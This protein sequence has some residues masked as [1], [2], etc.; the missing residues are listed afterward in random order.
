[1]KKFAVIFAFVALILAS[2]TKQAS[3]V[4]N[5]IMYRDVKLP[6]Q[7]MLEHQTITTPI[8]ASTTYILSGSA[9]SS[10]AT[11]NVTTFAHQPDV[12]RVLTATPGG[13]TANVAAGNVVITGLDILGHSITD[14]LA[15]TS[16]QSTTTTGTKAFASVS[17]IVLPQSGGT[18]VTFSVGVANAL[19][20]KRCMDAA[21]DLAWAM[22]NSAFESTRGTAVANATDESLN[23][24]TPNG[25]LDGT[26]NVDVFFVQ[27]FRCSP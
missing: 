5:Q 17:S 3:A 10:S 16:T 21:G 13:T 6:T 4:N 11:T 20:L 14:T 2:A 22:F 8:V 25:T 27:N 19:G 12:A 23:T 18:G 15:I 9:A 1:M 24:Y 7:A 26:K